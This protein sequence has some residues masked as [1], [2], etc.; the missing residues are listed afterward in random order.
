VDAH[1]DLAY[2]AVRGRPV[3][4]PAHQQKPDE[5]GIPT[6]GL[7]DLRDGGVGLIC[8]TIFC[9]P[10]YDDKPG[11]QTPDEAHAA[12]LTQL[13]WYQSQQSAGTMRI[14]QRPA[15]FSRRVSATQAILL[16]EG[17]DPLRDETDV[18]N[19]FESGLGIVGL[20]WKEGTRY[21]GGNAHPG[22]LTR[23]GAAMVKTLDRLGIIH[24]LSH[25]ADEAFWQLLA[26]SS[27][28]VMASHSNCR[29]I[30]PGE[31]QLSDEM[32][33][34]IA[35]RGGMIGINFFDRFLVPPQEQTKR[36]ATLGDVTNHVKHICDIAGSAA[37][38]GLGTDMDGGLGRNEIPV[39]IE[40]SAD[41]IR[42]ADALA[43]AGFG[44]QDVAAIMGKN[45]LQFFSKNLGAQH[46]K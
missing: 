10:R 22:P 32:I 5:D 25:L 4:L 44:D 18:R 28:P 36:R 21:A 13:H 23:D 30:V 2:N 33:R 9:Q 27:A 17:A 12:A 46:A 11:Y 8:A 43:A 3:H 16:M 1:L 35:S 24:D 37:H 45:W 31:R 42:V 15:D 34:A 38:V 26:L 41:L 7:P 39:E 29:S 40:T 19:F 20:T 6:V 14:L